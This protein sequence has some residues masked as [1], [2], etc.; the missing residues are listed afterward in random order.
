[1]IPVLGILICGYII[2]RMAEIVARRDSHHL[3]NLLAITMII[4]SLAGAAWLAVTGGLVDALNS[5][6]GSAIVTDTT[7]QAPE[8][9]AAP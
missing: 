4:A 8:L 2:V 1:M 9:P 5:S 3:L 7:M 6:A